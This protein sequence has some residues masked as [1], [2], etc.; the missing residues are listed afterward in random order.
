[1]SID[2]AVNDRSDGVEE[3]ERI[4]AG[5]LVIASASAGEVSGPVAMIT[6]SQS[7]DGSVANLL[8]RE[9]LSADE[10]QARR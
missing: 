5:G 2:V 3:R 6:L 7:A 10:P 8:A 1:M 9:F 4:L